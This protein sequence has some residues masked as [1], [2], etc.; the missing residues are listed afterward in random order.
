MHREGK[1]RVVDPP[2]LEMECF[3]RPDS[4]EHASL[5][6]TAEDGMAEEW[7]CHRW[8]GVHE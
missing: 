7:P 1:E 5:L 6:C 3:K 4:Y 8:A 2:P